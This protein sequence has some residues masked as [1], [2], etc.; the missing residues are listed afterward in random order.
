MLRVPNLGGFPAFV[1]VSQP[2]GEQ[3]P[4]I[5]HEI[6]LQRGQE[7]RPNCQGCGVAHG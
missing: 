5:G 1:S 2:P 4:G 7:A 3:V 6:P